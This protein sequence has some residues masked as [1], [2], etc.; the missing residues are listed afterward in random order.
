MISRTP[1]GVREVELD[2]EREVF[3]IFNRVSGAYLHHMSVNTGDSIED[4]IDTT[5]CKYKKV[6]MIPL[7]QTWEGD[8]NKGKI[9]NVEDKIASIDEYTLNSLAKNK[10]GRKY[11]PHHQLNILAKCIV[12]IGDKLGIDSKEFD[13]LNDMLEYIE[14][15]LAN[16]RRIKESYK[17]SPEY[18]YLTKED[19]NVKMSK[20]L[21]GGLA[22]VVGRPEIPVETPWTS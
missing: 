10:I 19:I 18:E 3:L 1:P 15:I 2:Q 17:N 12:K 6:K 4:L 5:Y 20:A 21:D 7:L 13:E 14:Q 8:Y 9:I 11:K 16:N 22:S